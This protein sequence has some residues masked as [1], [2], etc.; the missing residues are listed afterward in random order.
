MKVLVRWRRVRIVL[1]WRAARRDSSRPLGLKERTIR[2][3]SARILAQ[4][5]NFLLR[6]GSMM[7]LSRLLN[8]RDFGLVN[9]VTAFTGVLALFRDFGL[10]AAS[11]QRVTVTEEQTST[12]FWINVAT[13]AVLTVVA[14]ASAPLVGRF[15]HEP[16]LV[17]VTSVV[18]VAFLIN[19]FGVQHS[20]MLQRQMRFSRL[21]SIDI[22]ALVIGTVIAIGLAKLGLGYWAL[23]AM[24]VSG[25]FITTV[26]VWRATGWFP[27]PPERGVGLRPLMR[28][29]V[30]MTLNGLILYVA[31]NF[32]NVLL[33]RFW[34]AEAIGIYS[35]AYQLIRIPTDNLNSSVGEV[36]FAALSRVQDQPERLKRYF[37]K[38][39]SLVLALTLP[40]TIACALFAD[41]VILVL[42]GP[43]WKAAGV[44]F[45]LLAPTILV[46]AIANPLGWLLSALGLVGRGLKIALAFA[47]FMIIG[48]LVGLPYGPKGV[49]MTY[50]IVMTVWLIPTIIWAV[51]GTVISV[52]DIINAPIRPMVSSF[53]AAGI[54]F[55]VQYFYGPMLSPLPRLAV[56]GI[57]LVTAYLGMLLFVTGKRSFYL[58]LLRGSKG[59]TPA[60]ENSL[61]SA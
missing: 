25:P 50:S 41:D 26:A 47:P 23:V 33:G 46:F 24:T 55:G 3:G 15:Y 30:T 10:S 40:M 34:G 5:V 57:V 38:G 58:D 54:A 21:A 29:G 2:G 60:E 4:A 17:W 9:M 37:L 42:L 27:G 56:E 36:A 6:I 44:I 14:M 45:R 13:G 11:V 31:Y 39:Y 1:G 49:A 18:A 51:H 19:G 32:V 35:R 20:A 16:R 8:P 53:V 28:F 48:T 7:V 59:P 12:L 22:S 61:A 43:K 52:W